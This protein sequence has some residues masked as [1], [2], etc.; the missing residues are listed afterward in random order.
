MCEDDDEAT[1]ASG[2][3]RTDKDNEVPTA[4]KDCGGK[5]GA[6]AAMQGKKRKERRRMMNATD[7]MQRTHCWANYISYP[8]TPPEGIPEGFLSPGICYLINAK[9]I[10]T[11]LGGTT[12]THPTKNN[13]KQHVCFTELR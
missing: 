8:V 9:T 11:L 12:P 5:Q 4:I 13:N 2:L 1:T 3:Y 10:Q 7:R 6:N